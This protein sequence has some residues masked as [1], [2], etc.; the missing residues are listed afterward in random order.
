[1]KV[2]DRP[3]PVSE[4]KGPQKPAARRH[5]IEFFPAGDCHRYGGRAEIRFNDGSLLRLGNDAVVTLQT[6]YGDADGEFT[7]IKLVSGLISLRPKLERSVYQ[8]IC[9][10]IQFS[11]YLSGS[12]YG[13]WES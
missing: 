5:L 1:M 2:I 13:L 10:F 9:N 12:E 8:I 4:R 6:V 11:T 7:Q 3:K